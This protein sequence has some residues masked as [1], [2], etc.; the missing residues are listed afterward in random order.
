MT[1]VTQPPRFA[2]LRWV[3]WL[4][5]ACG[6]VGEVMV[7]AIALMLTYEV[8][9]RYVFVAPTKWTQDIAITLQI[10]FTYLGMAL[11]LR[12]R[13]L[14]RITAFLSIAP[15][16]MRY[17]LEGFAL[18][19]IGAFSA[20]AM[21]WGFEMLLDSIRL[22]RRQPTMLALPNWI[23]EIPIVIGFSLLLLQSIADLIRLPFG[24]A[25]SFSPGGEHDTEPSE[26]KTASK[27]SS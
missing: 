2:L 1:T 25:P 27:P 20:V 12:N 14:I 5:A 3:D 4:S 21:V 15:A 11:V 24:P 23:A 26:E 13:Q 8:I 6:R 10:W 7:V 17:V 18:V 16:K 22:M 9:A 19:V